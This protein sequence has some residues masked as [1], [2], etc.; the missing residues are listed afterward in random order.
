MKD[1]SCRREP[2]KREIQILNVDR[3]ETFVFTGEDVYPY[4]IVSHQFVPPF[5]L[6]FRGDDIIPPIVDWRFHADGVFGL[7]CYSEYKLKPP[8]AAFYKS[9]KILSFGLLLDEEDPH[10]DINHVSG[11][12]SPFSPR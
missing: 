9:S 1:G 7:G 8:R 12:H 3:N 4:V 6:N 2:W 11:A 10:I 5:P